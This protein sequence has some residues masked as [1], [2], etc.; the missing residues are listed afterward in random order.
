MKKIKFIGA[1]LVLSLLVPSANAAELK[2]G[3]VNVAVVLDK[4][5]QKEKALSRLETEFA[6]RSK[7]LEDKFKD[8]REKQDKLAQDSAILSAYER[9]TEER[10]ILSEQRELKR[11]QDEYNE[12]LSIRRNEELRKLEKD[13]AQTITDLAKK[14][15]YDL[16]LYQGVIHASDSLNMTNEV[17]EILKAK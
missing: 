5:P 3:V 10:S 17:L 13:I 9:K 7:S 15:S 1:F 16:V 8:L 4:S 2:I 11:L 6:T 14:E 12:D